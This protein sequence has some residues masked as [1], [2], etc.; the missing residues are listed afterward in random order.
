MKKILL[1]FLSAILLVACSEDD[2]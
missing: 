2:G 1:A